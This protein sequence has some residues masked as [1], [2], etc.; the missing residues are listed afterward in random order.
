MVTTLSRKRRRIALWRLKAENVMEL[1]PASIRHTASVRSAAHALNKHCVEMAPVIDEHSRLIG[2]VSR[3]DLADYFDTSG[4]LRNRRQSCDTRNL[5]NAGIYLKTGGKRT[6]V[7]VQQ[8]M[9]PKVF[10]VRT[11]ASIAQVIEEF[12]KRRI[13]RLF[14]TDQDGVLVG[15]INIFELLQTLGEYVNPIRISRQRPK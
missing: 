11:D 7:T 5:T 6:G 15:E 14:T 12:T 8:I 3:A 13:R 1:K 10:S 9:S 4:R 2:I